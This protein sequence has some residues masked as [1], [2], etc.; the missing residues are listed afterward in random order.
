MLGLAVVVKH[1]VV[2]R[3]S[4]GANSQIYRMRDYISID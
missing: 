1:V 4:C 3:I 2:Y